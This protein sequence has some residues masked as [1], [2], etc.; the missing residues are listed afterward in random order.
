MP[1]AIEAILTQGSPVEPMLQDLL[2][3]R[4]HDIN[5]DSQRTRHFIA[6]APRRARRVTEPD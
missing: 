5:A 6:F 2:A 4:L 3:A 1:E